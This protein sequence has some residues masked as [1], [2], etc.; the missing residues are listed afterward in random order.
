MFL[1][2]FCEL[3]MALEPKVELRIVLEDNQIEEELSFT[4]STKTN[5]SS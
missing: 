2:D 3:S 1:Y 5:R 4:V